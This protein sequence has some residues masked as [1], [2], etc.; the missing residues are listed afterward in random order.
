[1]ITPMDTIAVAEAMFDRGDLHHLPVVEN[2][3]LVGLLSSSDLLKCFLLDGGAASA[4]TVAVRS[5]M[6]ADPVS[7]D[8]RADL[9]SAAR[10]LST[11]GFHALPVTEPDGS[12]V[13]IVTSS[14]LT[15][16]LLRQLPSNDGSLRGSTAGSD[17]ESLTAGQVDRAIAVAGE[18]LDSGEDSLLARAVLDLVKRNHRMR[19]VC[20]AAEHYIRSGLAEREHSVLMKRLTDLRNLKESVYL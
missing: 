4:G 12:V 1:M 5:I 17:A 2:G 11:G 16:H 8:S 7:I 13:G 3:R 6:V 9:K 10:K 15:E 14:D 18:T 19:D 20:R